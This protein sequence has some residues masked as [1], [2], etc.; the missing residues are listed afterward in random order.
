M[1]KFVNNFIFET[2]FQHHT[3]LFFIEKPYLSEKSQI[4]TLHMKRKI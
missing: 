2:P 4:E 1:I 3:L